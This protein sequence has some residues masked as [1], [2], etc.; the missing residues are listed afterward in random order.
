MDL[1]TVGQRVCEA[2]GSRAALGY[3][4]APSPPSLEAPG[5]RV[6]CGDLAEHTEGGE[7]SNKPRKSLKKYMCGLC[8]EVPVWAQQERV[9][10]GSAG[11][12]RQSKGGRNQTVKGSQSLYL[13][14][15][16]SSN[17]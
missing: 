3:R 2:E 16:S 1:R 17:I 6:S 5:P 15:S 13:D 14:P 8:Q 11:S 4:A 12:K 7:Q 9:E 10:G